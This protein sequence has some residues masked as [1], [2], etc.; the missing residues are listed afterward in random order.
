MFITLYDHLDVKLC[1]KIQQK[2][3]RFKLYVYRAYML[4]AKS[5]NN[6]YV[7]YKRIIRTW[8]HN[9]FKKV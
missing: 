9:A 3:S 7:I 6:Y 8:L 5:K 1:D 2:S 4:H